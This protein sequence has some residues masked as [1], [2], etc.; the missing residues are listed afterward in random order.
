MLIV[1]LAWHTE[2]SFLP[3]WKFGESLSK[4]ASKR[5][6]FSHVRSLSNY[7]SIALQ[8]DINPAHESHGVPSL[9]QNHNNICEQTKKQTVLPKQEIF[10]NSLRE[11][12]REDPCQVS[13]SQ[14]ER[15]QI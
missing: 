13:V 6:R 12:V 4:K 14:V 5:A 1:P 10:L 9:M 11:R 2:L 8:K 15:A 7:I 3:P